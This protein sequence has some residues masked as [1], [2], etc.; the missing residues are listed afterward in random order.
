MRKLFS[1]VCLLGGGM[2]LPCALR[3]GEGQP[4]AV[5]QPIGSPAWQRYV[6]EGRDSP[7]GL[8]YV[9]VLD[10]EFRKPEL[11]RQLGGFVGVW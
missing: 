8:D 1:V 7:F 4:L 10:R 5:P 11:A 2:L 6:D 9:F 3:A